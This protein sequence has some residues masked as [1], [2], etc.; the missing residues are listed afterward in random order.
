MIAYSF[1]LKNIVIV[2]VLTIAVGF[3]LAWRRRRRSERH[4]VFAVD[5]RLQVL[6]ALF[7][8]GQTPPGDRPAGWQ[9]G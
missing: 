2:D 4:P 8:A 3:V 6:L 5:V 9:L 7:W 1:W